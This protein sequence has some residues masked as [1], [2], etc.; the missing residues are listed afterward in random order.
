[1]RGELE[2]L[3]CKLQNGLK[4]PSSQK[5]SLRGFVAT[6]Q[7]RLKALELVLSTEDKAAADLAAYVEKFSSQPS[8]TPAD[9]DKAS[10]VA[11]AAAALG[12]APPSAK[13]KDLVTLQEMEHDAGQLTNSGVESALEL[14]EVLRTYNKKKAPVQDLQTSAKKAFADLDRALKHEAG[15]T[16]AGPSKAADPKREQGQSTESIFDFGPPVLQEIQTV[17]DGDPRAAGA[18]TWEKPMR[19][20]KW[21][22]KNAELPKELLAALDFNK[23]NF[24][25]KVK[26][27]GHGCQVPRRQE[28][29]D[30][31]SRTLMDA[32]PAACQDCQC[33]PLL[34]LP[35]PS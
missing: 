34:T 6:G 23:N 35:Q 33:C 30:L 7:A 5:Q 9:D 10:T 13:Y 27:A 25:A 15:Q 20:A 32:I 17:H 31:I 21:S 18:V 2:E 29:Q 11:V 12:S 26:S 14:K 4:H 16:S 28:F 22:A 1:M 3:K 24:I 19:F 8:A